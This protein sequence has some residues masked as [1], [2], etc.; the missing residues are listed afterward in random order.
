MGFDNRT[1][2]SAEL[3][4]QFNLDGRLNGVVAVRGAFDLVPDGVMKASAEQAPFQWAD[5]YDGEPHTA[6]LIAPS[7]F[8]PYKPGTDVTFL[9]SSHAPKGPAATWVCGI[10]VQGHRERLLRVHGPRRWEPQMRPARPSLMG[11]SAEPQFEGWRLSEA[12]PADSVEISWRN[13]FGGTRPLRPG[14]APPAEAHPFNGLGPGLIDAHRSPRDQPLPAPRIEAFDDPILD[15]RQDHEPQGLAPVPPWWRFRQRHVGT[16]D[17]KWVRERHPVL[18][19]DFDYHF[20]QTAHPAMV[21]EPWLAGDELIELANLHPSHPMLRTR[22]PRLSLTVRLRRPGLP[23]SEGPL[24]LDG[25]HF[26]LRDGASKAFLTWRTAFPY[27]TE[28]GEVELLLSRSGSDD[29]A[30]RPAAAGPGAADRSGESWR[31]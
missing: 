6:Q 13:A 27:E 9:G 19:A 8:V 29:A 23:P 10:R 7:D 25:V 2:F 5:E 20:Y 17:D 18:P 4:R 28:D 11:P 21:F 14:Q 31:G 26:D 3:F 1:G 30:R 12:E 15:W 24:A 16:I 22:L